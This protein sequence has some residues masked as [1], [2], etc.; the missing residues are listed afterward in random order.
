ML[1]H[2]KKSRHNQRGTHKSVRTRTLAI[3]DLK[4]IAQYN[5]QEQLIVP[6]KFS[7]ILGKNHLN[8]ER[9]LSRSAHP[10]NLERLIKADQT[11][12]HPTSFSSPKEMRDKQRKVKVKADVINCNK[13][14]FKKRRKKAT[15]Y[16]HI[17][18]KHEYHICKEGSE[19]L[20]SF[21]TLIDHIEKHH[22]KE[23]TVNLEK[24]FKL[25]VNSEKEPN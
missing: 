21:M 12:F 22:Q 3:A 8:L 7:K 17:T 14:D 18:T 13:C 15:L 4:V 11:I 20:Q 6:N 25:A 24:R 2:L 5:H 1:A 19:K 23:L 9:L 10:L 16:K